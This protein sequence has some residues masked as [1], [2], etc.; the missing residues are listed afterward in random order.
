MSR[1]AR[2]RSL[3]GFASFVSPFAVRVWFTVAAA[4]R[5]A[6]SSGR[7]RFLRFDLM[8]S[9][10]RSR[11]SVQ[12]ACGIRVTSRSRACKRRAR[13]A[14]ETP[15]VGGKEVPDSFGRD[16]RR[17]S[18]RWL[19][20]VVALAD[21]DRRRQR[22]ETVLGAGKE[23]GTV[24]DVRV[25]A[26]GKA[27]L[28]LQKV[29]LLVVINQHVAPRRQ[30]QSGPRDLR[31]LKDAVPIRQDGDVAESPEPRHDLD[32][33]WKQIAFE[34]HAQ[35]R[36]VD[37]RAAGL[38]WK[39]SAEATQRLGEIDDAFLAAHFLIQR[40][41]AQ[42]AIGGYKT[43]D[44]APDV[45]FDAVVVEERVI[46]VEEEHQVSAHGAPRLNR[47]SN[48]YVSPDHG[49]RYPADRAAR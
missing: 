49:L 47:F 27:P 20:R 29:I 1:F 5:S 44:S 43:R 9:Y 11:L 2:A 16:V 6:V 3:G 17:R 38:V 30:E 36:T 39:C 26:S 12:A 32:R 37:V 31:R 45:L 4:I 8:W 34:R 19:R 46:H 7:P 24:V 23:R 10:C 15:G 18:G 33:A 42:G 35:H 28:D 48:R 14:R 40:P 25:V 41:K 22:P 21:V 13:T